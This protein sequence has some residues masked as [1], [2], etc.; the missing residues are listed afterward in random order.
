MEELTTKA[1]LHGLIEGKEYILKT[2]LQWDWEAY[3]EKRLRF[4]VPQASLYI[5]ED[6]EYIHW[7]C[8]GSSAEE[9]SLE[10]LEWLLDKIFECEAS[11]FVELNMNSVLDV[12]NEG[13]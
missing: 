11:D 4:F 2:R 10:S 1:L 13:R 7:Q 5:D 12:I 3:Q 8:H 9:I 6:G